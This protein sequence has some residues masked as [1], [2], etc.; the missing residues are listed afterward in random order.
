MKTCSKNCLPAEK[1]RVL[2]DVNSAALFEGRK[3][4]PAHASSRLGEVMVT[5]TDLTKQ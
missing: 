3:A 4:Q 2:Q 1:F 5:C